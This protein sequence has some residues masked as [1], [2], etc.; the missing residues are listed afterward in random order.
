MSVAR[1][2]RDGAVAAA[3]G[4]KEGTLGDSIYRGYG[5]GSATLNEN[6]ADVLIESRN[7]VPVMISTK[8]L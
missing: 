4:S 3:S 1:G 7:G 8:S 2:S 5:D 6:D